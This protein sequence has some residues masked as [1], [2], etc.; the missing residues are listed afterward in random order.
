MNH[1]TERGLS[2]TYVPTAPGEARTPS[3]SIDIAV[4]MGLAVAI[5]AFH[6]LTG[7]KVLEDSGGD[8]DSLLRLVQ[9]RALL[10]GQGWFDLQ[11]YRMGLEGGFP[12]HWSRLIDLPIAV[13]ILTGG[14]FGLSESAAEAFALTAWPT[15]LFV[16]ALFLIVDTVRRMGNGAAVLPALVIGTAALLFTGEFEPGAIDHHNAQLVL[17]L[18]MLNRLVAGSGF[19]NGL[20]AGVLAA[21]SI[22]VGM[23]TAPYVAVAG[24]GVALALIFGGR[25]VPQLAAGFGLAFFGATAMAFLALVA[26][27]SWTSASC[28]ALS[29]FQF[30][31]AA[32]GGL[33]LSAAALVTRASTPIWRAT[34]V[35]LVGALT[36]IL[37][38]TAFPQCL[39]SPFG[40]LDPRM[41][42]LWLD[43]V[44]EA[45]SFFALLAA[46]PSMVLG[47]YVTPILGLA[48]LILM[49]GRR[50]LSGGAMLLAAML[51]T[52]LAV[53]MW[54]VRGSTFSIPLAT[55]ALAM[56]L[57]GLRANVSRGGSRLAPL[58]LAGG[59]L[60]STNV[61][62]ALAGAVLATMTSAQASEESS[63]GCYA[64]SDYADLAALSQ[65]TVLAVSNLGASIV[66]HTEHRA[67][68]GPYHRNQAGNLATLDAL[69]AEPDAAQGLILANGIDYVAVC[70]GNAE[71]AFL[72][73]RA[74]EG[75]LAELVAGKTPDWLVPAV[76]SDPTRPLMVYAIRIPNQSR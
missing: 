68:A 52:S 28:D 19:G 9:I 1:S 29:S 17:V 30:A 72:T 41:R 47:Y 53:S 34:A 71:T 44:I 7:F 36:G 11:Q 55:I 59:W 48:L 67:L 22:A 57:G 60:V 27:S 43:H 76:S 21:L 31:V 58:V 39:E 42:S 51:A 6:A 26:P 4:A 70:P 69:M 45:Q 54:Q 23:E 32:L 15:L 46:R 25:S 56:W 40:D 50:G 24:S 62:W 2:R 61:V 38:L 13:L 20:A 16:A 18:A 64:R 37:V 74:P 49:I 75:L 65:G 3:W 73:R 10:D 12:L 63:S 33:G 5:L 14:A 35:A 66:V 8:N